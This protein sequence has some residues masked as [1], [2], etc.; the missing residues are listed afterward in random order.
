MKEFF[1]AINLF[2]EI[3]ERLCEQT[4]YKSDV[5]Y[6][7]CR[8]YQKE[9]KKLLESQRGTQEERMA[10]EQGIEDLYTNDPLLEM[11]ASDF[12]ERVKVRKNDSNR[13]YFY[14]S[15]KEFLLE[16]KSDQPK[17]EAAE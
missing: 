11:T 10:I 6:N 3:V 17:K 7:V 8:G 2:D 12:L 4:G 14:K 16:H 15:K 9:F 13:Q 1:E 5:V